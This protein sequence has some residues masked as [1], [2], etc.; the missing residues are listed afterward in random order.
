MGRTRERRRDLERQIRQGQNDF[1]RQLASESRESAARLLNAYQGV[2]Q[3]INP[4]LANIIKLAETSGLTGRDLVSSGEMIRLRDDVRSGF[5]DFARIIERESRR[6]ERAGIT[7]GRGFGLNALETSDVGIS[8]NRPTVESIQSLI[9][10]VDSAAF[11]KNLNQFGDYYARYASDMVL[12]DASRGVNPRTTAR[13]LNKYFQDGMPYYDA[14]RMTRTVQIYS[15]RRGTSEI[16]KA[17]RENCL[18][19]WWGSALDART[20]VSCLANH[21]KTFSVDEYLRD[22]HRGRCGMIPITPTWASLGFDDGEDMPG[23]TSGEAWFRSLPE[24]QQRKIMGNAKFEAWKDG[25]FEF[26]DL[27]TPYQDKVYGTMYHAPSLKELRENRL[28]RSLTPEK[29]RPPTID[30]RQPEQFPYYQARQI[31][32]QNIFDFEDDPSGR[33]MSDFFAYDENGNEVFRRD[34]IDQSY[35]DMLYN[36]YGLGRANPSQ[37]DI[38]RARTHAGAILSAYDQMGIQISK[39]QRNQLTRLALGDVEGEINSIKDNR[40]I[41]RVTA[42]GGGG[43]GSDFL[44][45]GPMNIEGTQRLRESNMSWAAYEMSQKDVDY[46]FNPPF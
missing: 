29:F 23:P 30:I 1:R 28:E 5:N 21:G 9:H 12:V 17:N 31:T 25:E 39:K 16:Y 36:I 7:G 20:C 32:P 4:T 18:G 41:G 15:A 37:A 45:R 3:T 42:R 14:E 10:Y 2:L 24:S 33:V 43:G 27:T 19:W 26:G 11:Q 35:N 34:Y 22:H 40:R 44:G 8:W 46:V 13:H 38:D 6:M